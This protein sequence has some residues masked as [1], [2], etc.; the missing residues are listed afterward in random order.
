M[1]REC[2]ERFPRHRLQRKP[3]VS[4]PGMHHGTCVTHAPWRM[5][6]PLNRNG[7][8]NVPGIPDACGTQNLAHLVRGP[9]FRMALSYWRLDDIMAY[10]GIGLTTLQSVTVAGITY[11]QRSILH[12]ENYCMINVFGLD[13]R[14]FKQIRRKCVYFD[15]MVTQWWHKSQIQFFDDR[16]VDYGF[17][18]FS[19]QF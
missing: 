13:F 15:T 7:G 9:C 2:R 19:Y 16:H 3:L 12:A 6:E 17:L 4:D 11:A 18:K 10:D 5:P 14:V 1:R 8:E